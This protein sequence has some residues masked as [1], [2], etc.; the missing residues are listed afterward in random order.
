MKSFKKLVLLVGIACLV[1]SV[2]AGP[3]SA[4]A[5]WILKYG[6]GGNTN[7]WTTLNEGAL[8][9][10]YYVEKHTQ[11][12][13]EV[14]IYPAFQLGNFRQMM[15]QVQ[16]NTLEMCHTTAGG[17]SSFM[18]EF[19]VVDMPYFIGDEPLASIF[20]TTSILERDVS[21]IFEENRKRAVAGDHATGFPKLFDNETNQ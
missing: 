8:F 6:H 7:E 2:G 1:L 20:Y 13:V 15:E 19:N 9:I 14:Q 17:A 21:R 4:K 5:K 3:V 10:K 18:P 11:G 16:K 12:E